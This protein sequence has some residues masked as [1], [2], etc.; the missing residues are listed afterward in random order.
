MLAGLEDEGNKFLRLKTESLG[1]N[2]KAMVNRLQQLVLRAVTSRQ[3]KLVVQLLLM[4]SSCSRLDEYIACVREAELASSGHK[5]PAEMTGRSGYDGQ[6]EYRKLD[7]PRLRDSATK[8]ANFLS[9]SMGQDELDSYI[10]LIPQHLQQ[11]QQQA[12]AS[13]SPTRD[14]E[15]VLCRICEKNILRALY[16][17]HAKFCG[18]KGL[19]VLKQ[20][21]VS[22]FLTLCLWAVGHDMEVL[23]VDQEISKLLH[24]MK[25]G[26]ALRGLMERVLGVRDGGFVECMQLR[27][28]LQTVE[29]S[30]LVYI[31]VFF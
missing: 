30:S 2:S 23:V 22:R 6:M 29:G 1:P 31:C 18:Q 14:D 27:K 24:G 17:S 4:I 25:Q 19:F 12:V 21:L 8:R 5:P 10:E 7:S 11:Q 26:S 9:V 15:E 28:Q 3:K 16:P 20:R 13:S